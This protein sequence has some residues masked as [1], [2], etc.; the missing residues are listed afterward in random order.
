[1]HRVNE[2]DLGRG[3]QGGLVHQLNEAGPRRGPWGRLVHQ[4]NDDGFQRGQW[5]RLVHQVNDDGFQRGQWGRLVHQLNDDRPG[6]AD[7]PVESALD[8]QRSTTIDAMPAWLP[9]RRAFRLTM[10][11][12]M[13][14]VDRVTRSMNAATAFV[15]GVTPLRICENT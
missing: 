1:V 5:G 15:A 11:W 4:V 10:N 6:G 7:G 8:G 3:R 14:S 13:S 9:L 12:P 2:T